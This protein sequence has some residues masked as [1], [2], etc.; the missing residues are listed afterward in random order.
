MLAGLDDDRPGL[1]MFSHMHLDMKPAAEDMEEQAQRMMYN[2]VVKIKSFHVDTYDLGKPSRAK[3]YAKVME[4]L[5]TG[6]TARTHV[7]LFNDRHFV[8]ND[9]K[10]RWIA[11]IEWA[12]FELKV[13]PNESVPSAAES[14]GERKDAQAGGQ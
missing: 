1:S 5:Y 11:H 6:V 2:K 8:D 13:T 14:E 3:A 4:T 12:V 9:D 7:I 10:P